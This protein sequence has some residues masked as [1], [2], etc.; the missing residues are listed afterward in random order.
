MKLPLTAKIEL[1]A[2]PNDIPLIADASTVDLVTFSV[3]YFIKEHA[4][5]PDPQVIPVNDYNTQIEI[6]NQRPPRRGRLTVRDNNGNI[7]DETIYSVVKIY[8][9]DKNRLD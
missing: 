8:Y 9:Y 4:G 1:Q 2:K 7:L 3:S 6:L 5:S